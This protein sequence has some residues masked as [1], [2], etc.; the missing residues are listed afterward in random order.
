VKDGIGRY[1]EEAAKQGRH[2]PAGHELMD[3]FI[4]G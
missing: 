1:D 2:F 4:R 3:Y